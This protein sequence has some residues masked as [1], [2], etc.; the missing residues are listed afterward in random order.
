M[1]ETIILFFDKDD[2][3]VDTEEEAV[4]A[5]KWI[6]DD[7]GSALHCACSICCLTCSGDCPNALGTINPI[8][9]T[10]RTERSRIFNTYRKRFAEIRFFQF[11]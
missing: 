5:Q 6:F 8:I 1:T 9:A 4:T 3:I 11:R 10:A 7:D 2:N